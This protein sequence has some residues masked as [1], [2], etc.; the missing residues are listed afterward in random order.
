MTRSRN[1]TRAIQMTD[2]SGTVSTKPSVLITLKSIEDA[3]ARGYKQEF[4][5][6]DYRYGF[7]KKLLGRTGER[8]L[9]LKKG[10]REGSW[11]A[12]FPRNDPLCNSY[13]PHVL[14]ANMGNVDWRP[15]LN[16]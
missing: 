16:L 11:E 12:L 3:C 13:E 9:L 1:G 2:T 10:D 8:K 4:V 15:C 6:F 14:L 7:P 5:V